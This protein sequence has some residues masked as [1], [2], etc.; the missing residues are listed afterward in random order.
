[1]EVRSLAVVDGRV[2]HGFTLS[3][4]WLGVVAKLNR[5]SPS[6]ASSRTSAAEEAIRGGRHDSAAGVSTSESITATVPATATE[7]VR[8]PIVV[9]IAPSSRR[10]GRLPVA[11]RAASTV[12]RAPAG[13]DVLGR[14]SLARIPRGRHRYLTPEGD[15]VMT[16]ASSPW[17]SRHAGG[18]G[19]GVILDTSGIAPNRVGSFPS[20]G[21]VPNGGSAP[22]HTRGYPIAASGPRAQISSP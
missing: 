5:P 7:K 11:S 16:T 8:V 22:V 4:P 6:T 20:P 10:L 13:E 3:A 18:F 19:A 12:V 1:M 21:L 9:P 14:K 17:S 2:G 15:A